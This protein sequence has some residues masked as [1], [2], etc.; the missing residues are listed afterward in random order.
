MNSDVLPAG[1]GK[2]DSETVRAVR[3]RRL[4]S[5]PGS[6]AFGCCDIGEA[7]IKYDDGLE[8]LALITWGRGICPDEQRWYA[9][10][11]DYTP[12]W[13]GQCD[14]EAEVILAVGPTSEVYQWIMDGLA[15]T[16]GD[17]PW[18]EVSD[19]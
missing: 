4:G 15:L 13:C 6:L 17:I 19:G 10:K 1:Y 9:T 18:R 7:L 11:T 14:G 12:V 8:G 16:A 2:C 5:L 3:V